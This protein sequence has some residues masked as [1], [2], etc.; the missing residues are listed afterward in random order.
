MESFPMWTTDNKKSAEEH[1]K[2]ATSPKALK[3]LNALTKI[4][5]AV[6]PCLSKNKGRTHSPLDNE[7]N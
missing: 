3:C 1:G 2:A 5:G 4:L 7:T 6:L